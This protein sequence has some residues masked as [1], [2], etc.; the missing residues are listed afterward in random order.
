MKRIGVFAFL[1]LL[2]V[3]SFGTSTLT[4]VAELSYEDEGSNT[5]TGSDT[6]KIVVLSL[7]NVSIQKLVKNITRQ[8]A[9]QNEVNGASGD[10]LEYQVTL[11]NTGEDN[12]RYVVV[13]DVLSGSLTF[14][15]NSYG[16]GK[17]IEV[18]TETT[19]SC[20]NAKDGDMA[21]FSDSKIIVGKNKQ[22]N[23]GNTVELIIA[24]EKT[25][26]IRYQVKIK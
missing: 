4:N 5:Y 1:L 6:A 11:Q 3:V 17:G 16:T 2:P 24:P 15:E 21:N 14:Q 7:P 18:S 19:I 25:A 26:I 9:F 13:E 22:A 12:A 10:L 23:N 20:T 8:G